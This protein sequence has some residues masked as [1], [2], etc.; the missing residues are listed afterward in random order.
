MFVAAVMVALFANVNLRAF[1]QSCDRQTVCG[2]AW[3]LNC[4]ETNRLAFAAGQ[5][6]SVGLTGV[7]IAAEIWRRRRNRGG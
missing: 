7:F 1:S 3:D 6:V 5:Y 2:A 4:S